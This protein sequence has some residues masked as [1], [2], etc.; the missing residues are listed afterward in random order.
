MAVFFMNIGDVVSYFDL[1]AEA[2]DYNRVHLVKCE[3]GILRS[4]DGTV[5]NTYRL[6][7]TGDDKCYRVE[8]LNVM[9]YIELPTQSTK[10]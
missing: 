2:L 4:V 6:V 1:Y 9:P 8:Q 10:K 3:Y 7:Y 5:K